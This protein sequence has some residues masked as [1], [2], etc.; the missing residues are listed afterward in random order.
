MLRTRSYCRKRCADHLCNSGIT[1]ELFMDG[2]DKGKY[3]GWFYDQKQN[4]YWLTRLFT[5]ADH[6][7]VIISKRF[8]EVAA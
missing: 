3:I 4:T 7:E 6:N 2:M 5:T 1:A 8:T